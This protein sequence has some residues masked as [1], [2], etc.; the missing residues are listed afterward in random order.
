MLK[1]KKR[2]TKR[3]I[4]EDKFVTF[5]INATNYLQENRRYIMYGAF[6]FVALVVMFLIYS[7]K[8]SEKEQNAVIILTEARAEFGKANYKDAADKLQ[9]LVDTYGG[10][11][12]S[13]IGLFYLA[14]SRYHL[15]E[16][17]EAERL[18]REYLDNGKDELLLTSSMSGVAACLEEQGKPA[19]AAEM[20][21]KT[22]EKYSES[23]MAAENLYNA[24]RC[25]T[26][27]GNPAA[28]AKVLKTLIRD[29]SSSQ[30]K[31]DA[32]IFL[33]ELNP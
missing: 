17:E 27:A 13:T 25:Y 12:S 31:N 21:E 32:E 19:E 16:Y 28:A 22:A 20:F 2:L 9:I 5:Y 23:F 33:A 24:A 8:Q 4:K 6:A 26:L 30:K 3:Q 10:T 29:Y 7:G 18:F 1:A 11:K 15:Q 14:N